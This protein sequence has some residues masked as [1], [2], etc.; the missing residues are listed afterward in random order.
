[1]APHEFFGSAF[2][3]GFTLHLIVAEAWIHATEVRGEAVGI[4][5]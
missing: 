4:R 5:E 3:I 1:M 2:W